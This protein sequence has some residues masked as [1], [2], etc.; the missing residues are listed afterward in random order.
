MLSRPSPKAESRYKSIIYPPD[1]GA[2]L[3]RNCSWSAG[4][5][6]L[7]YAMSGLVGAQEVPGSHLIRGSK[8]ATSVSEALAEATPNATVITGNGIQYHNGPII[9]GTVH[10]YFVWY[11]NW[12]N[13]PHA[14][15]SPTTVSLLQG[16]FAPHVLGGSPYN[17][18][19]STYGDQSNNVTGNVQLRAAVVDNYSQGTKLTDATLGTVI[20]NAIAS[21][22][23]P[24]DANGVY[25]VLTSSDVNETSGLCKTYCA[26]HGHMTV[27]Q[28]DIKF[29]FAGNTDRCPGACEVQAVTPNGDSGADGMAN[30]MAHETEEAITDPDLNAWFNNTPTNEN[31]DLCQWKFGPLTGT[32]G[33]GAYNQTLGGRHWLI[34]MNWENARGGGCTQKLGGPFY[35]K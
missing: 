22:A 6:G 9:P 34:Q 1:M 26:F 18:I 15:D 10:V 25:E 12:V 24:L 33:Q 19:N 13:G 30:V 21:H 4:L 8:T 3:F 5:L 7:V 35:T 16:L 17:R 14:S 2:S 28:T 23:L 20:S 31:A 11:G 29:V 27:N 32:L